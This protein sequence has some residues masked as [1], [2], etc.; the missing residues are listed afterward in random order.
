MRLDRIHAAHVCVRISSVDGE[1]G[2]HGADQTPGYYLTNYFF[3]TEEEAE[4]RRQ[5]HEERKDSPTVKKSIMDCRAKK[6]IPGNLVFIL[7]I[8]LGR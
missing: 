6:G 3:I 4:L 8:L 7:M 1:V 2:K 5:I